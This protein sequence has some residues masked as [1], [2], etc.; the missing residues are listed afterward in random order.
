MKKLAKAA[1]KKKI[2]M[3]TAQKFK[4]GMRWEFGNKWTACFL[5]A[6]VMQMLAHALQLVI[7]HVHSNKLHE[8]VIINARHLVSKIRKSSC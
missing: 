2:R 4:I 8:F 1:L 7:K 3:K 5:S 6:N